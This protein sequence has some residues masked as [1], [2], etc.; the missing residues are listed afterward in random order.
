M[1]ALEISMNLLPKIYTDLHF[2]YSNQKILK[3]VNKVFNFLEVSYKIKKYKH[4]IVSPHYTTSIISKLIDNEIQNHKEGL[5]SGISLKLNN[6][7]NYP[8]G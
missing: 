4:L 5:P 6:I 1:S 3:E 8:L 2:I 7:T